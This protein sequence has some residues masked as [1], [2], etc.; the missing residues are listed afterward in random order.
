MSLS[1]SSQS[2][3]STSQWYDGRLKAA[4]FQTL[5]ADNYMP[6]PVN[7]RT[8]KSRRRHLMSAWLILG[9]DVQARLGAFNPL[10]VCQ[11]HT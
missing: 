6:T 2:R 3:N 4:W 8:L 9:L 11:T 7:I 10:H 5:I 1:L